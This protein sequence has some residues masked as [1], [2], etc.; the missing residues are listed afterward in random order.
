[1]V[2]AKGSRSQEIPVILASNNS[3]KLAELAGILPAKFNLIPQG[4]LNIPGVEETGLTFVENA[5]LKARHACDLGGYGAI[6]DDSGLEVDALNGAPGIYSSRYASG[7]ASDA[8]NIEKLLQEM[9]NQDNRAARFCCVIVFMK[10]KL[11][12]RPLIAQGVWEGRI[13][14]KP[15]GSYGFGYDPVFYVPEMQCSSAQLDPQVKNEISHR[16]IAMKQLRES[17]AGYFSVG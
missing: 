11:D 4:D 13:L 12:P 15:E 9:K 5:I 6:A 16:G 14:D 2:M 17:L 8:D 3:K 10:H 7:D 1:M